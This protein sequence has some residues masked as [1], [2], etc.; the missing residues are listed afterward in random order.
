MSLAPLQPESILRASRQAVIALSALSQGKSSPT[1]QGD[2]DKPG[3]TDPR[4]GEEIE[5]LQIW[6][7]EHEVESGKLDHRLREAPRLRERVLSL[8][9]ELSGTEAPTGERTVNCRLTPFPA[10]PAQKASQDGTGTSEGQS[11]PT[12]SDTG[13]VDEDLEATEPANIENKDNVSVESNSL[14]LDTEYTQ[15]DS[16]PD[17]PLTHVRDLVSLLMELGP[18][19]LEP[20]PHGRFEYLGYA[21]AAQHD[22]NHVRAR[23]PKADPE[24][25]E[26]LGRANWARRQNLGKVRAIV[27]QSM[28]KLQTLTPTEVAV[29]DYRADLSELK[30]ESEESE[31]SEGERNDLL[32]TKRHIHSS[33]VDEVSSRTASLTDPSEFQFSAMETQSTAATEPSK[34]PVSAGRVMKPAETLYRVPPPPRPNEKLTGA[35]FVCRFCA[36]TVSNMESVSEWK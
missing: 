15:P 30:S 11:R 26:R 9:E 25:V 3:T 28:S 10:I 27:E 4:Y 20:T 34:G 2:E 31:S 7:G 1:A 19:L 24:L 6:M 12:V 16:L 35:E 22:I 23:F 32:P 14:S 29:A 21:N 33:I 17:S 18:S 5:R 8:L 36:H 13:N